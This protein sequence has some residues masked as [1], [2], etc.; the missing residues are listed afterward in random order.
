MYRAEVDD[1]L[2]AAPH[3]AAVAEVESEFGF[4]RLSQ[5]R[6]ASEMKGV[7]PVGGVGQR[8]GPDLWRKAQEWC[9]QFVIW[10]RDNVTH[11]LNEKALSA[12]Y[13]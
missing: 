7:H 13:A 10:M 6:C 1:D 5:T 9:I 2:A 12:T 3:A 11:H 4:V 8:F